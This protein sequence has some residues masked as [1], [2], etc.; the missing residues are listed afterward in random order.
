[1]SKLTGPLR[2]TVRRRDKVLVVRIL[3]GDER[4]AL[5]ELPELLQRVRS[6]IIR[7]FRPAQLEVA[8]G[9]LRVGF[10]SPQ[11][12]ADASVRLIGIVQSELAP[13]AS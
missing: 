4:V 3:S 12:A 10:A 6:R 5:D 9:A 1:M 8:G 11:H 7:A 2:S 13:L